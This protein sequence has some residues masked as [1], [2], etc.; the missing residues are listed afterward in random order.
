MNVSTDLRSSSP[1]STSS[2]NLAATESNA[3]SGHYVNQS[4][5]V[6]L[7]KAGNFLALFLNASPTGEKQRAICKFF[8]TRSM[9]NFQQLSLLSTKPSP[10]TADLTLLTICSTSS[11]GKRSEISPELSKSLMKTRKRSLVICPS[12]NRNM[13]PS[14]LTPVRW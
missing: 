14:S 6:Q 3:S 12:V 5:T 7:I 11:A 8:L 4:I 2:R 9:K 1:I 10:L 13:M